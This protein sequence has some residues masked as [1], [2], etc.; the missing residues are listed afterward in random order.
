MLLRNITFMWCLL[1]LIR[2]RTFWVKCYFFLEGGMYRAYKISQVLGM[3]CFWISEINLEQKLHYVTASTASNHENNGL[4]KKNKIVWGRQPLICYFVIYS[5]LDNLC[6]PCFVLRKSNTY[7]YFCSAF[8]G[9][10]AM[11]RS[12]WRKQIG[13]I[14]DH[15]ECGGWMFLLVP[16]QPGCP[17]Q[18]T[19]SRKMIVCVC[20]PL[21]WQKRSLYA[22]FRYLLV[23]QLLLCKCF[24]L[25]RDFVYKL[26]AENIQ[27]VSRC[28]VKHC[29]ILSV[30]G[31]STMQTA[32][33]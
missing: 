25:F 4:I 29:M 15:D 9:L 30:T 32:K 10:D 6:K 28:E 23:M 16:A 31:Q 20:V 3:I 12:R 17:G 26:K 11:C 22:D 33:Q 5:S 14:D 24:V 8:I 18:I 1:F 2:G 27:Q 13:M 21:A 19:Q 7:S